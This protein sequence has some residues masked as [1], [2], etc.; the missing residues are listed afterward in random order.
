MKRTFK[1]VLEDR[2]KKDNNKDKISLIP[3]LELEIKKND[4]NDYDESLDAIEIFKQK[5]NKTL[6]E[7]Y[8]KCIDEDNE[9][10]GRMIIKLLELLNKDKKTNKKIDLNVSYLDLLKD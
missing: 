1:D 9:Q 8:I 2:L 10:K 6:L 7:F 5:H 3:S 4:N